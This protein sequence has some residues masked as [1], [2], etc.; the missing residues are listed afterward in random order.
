MHSIKR[1]F[2]ALCIALSLYACSP[3]PSAQRIE[4]KAK[5]VTIS[6]ATTIDPNEGWRTI[7]AAHEYLAGLHHAAEEKALGDWYAG[8]RR[9]ALTTQPERRV[10]V[11][12]N[13]T[14]VDWDCVAMAETGGNWR[15]SGSRYSTALGIMDQAVRENATPEVAVRALNGTATREEQIAIGESIVRKFGLRAWAYSTYLKCRR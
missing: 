15:M 7:V 2:G 9:P 11:G 13:M 3:A 4:V 1:V 5:V 10:D 12:S 8:L 14:G 6:T